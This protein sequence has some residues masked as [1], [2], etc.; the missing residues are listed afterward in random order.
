MPPRRQAR[1]ESPPAVT[2]VALQV[3][4]LPEPSPQSPKSPGKSAEWIHSELRRYDPT[5][6][7]SGPLTDATRD[8]RIKK[9]HHHEVREKKEFAEKEKK[10][11][12]AQKAAAKKDPPAAKNGRG[13]KRQNVEQPPRDDSTPEQEARYV[14]FQVTEPSPPAKR[15]KLTQVFRPIAIFKSVLVISKDL[16][17]V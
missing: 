12:L 13:G 9:I 5:Y 10:E 17:T 1:K 16:R 11:L 8:I 3:T 7:G 15:T 6:K 4:I 14:G 2:P